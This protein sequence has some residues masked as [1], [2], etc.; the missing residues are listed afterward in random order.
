MAIAAGGTATANSYSLAVAAD[1]TVYGWGDNGNGQLGVGSTTD[2]TRPKAITNFKVLPGYPEVGLTSTLDPVGAPGTVLLTATPTDPDGLTGVSVKFY[3]N[4]QMVLEKTSAP[5]TYSYTPTQAGS[6]HAFAVVKDLTLLEGQSPPA[7]FSINTPQVSLA[8]EVAPSY[9]PGTVVLTASPTDADGAGNLASVKF[10]VDGDLVGERTAPPW[11]CAHY[12]NDEGTY[13]ATAVVRDR[14][15]LE[16][17]SAPVSFSVH[18][19]LIPLAI[20][21]FVHENP[22]YVT[23]TASPTDADGVGN[24][25]Q[26]IFYSNGVPVGS[27]SMSPCVIEMPSLASGSYTVHAVVFDHFGFTSTSPSLPFTIHASGGAPDDDG[28]GITN[29]DEIAAGTS[30]TDTD[31]DND[32]IPDGQDASPL[33]PDFVSTTVSGLSV[34]APLR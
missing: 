27:S 17:T 21:A 8:A 13:P 24:L 18:A 12:P 6:Y 16:S 22:G 33:S 1:G 15:G 19:P 32:G 2:S 25:S 23:L 31:S 30:P 11:T 28:D 29:A 3:I 34:W 10:Y 7:N 26:V 20:S 9:A 4:G 14:F 5:W